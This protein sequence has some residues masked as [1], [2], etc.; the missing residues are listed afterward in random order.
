MLLDVN[1]NSWNLGDQG[2]CDPAP[3]L[4]LG[5]C[6][7]WREDAAWWLSQDP[8]AG[9]WQCCLITVAYSSWFLGSPVVIISPTS[10]SEEE[11]HLR[12]CISHDWRIVS[13]LTSAI[14]SKT[15]FRRQ[16]S[17]SHFGWFTD[18]QTKQ[19]LRGWRNT[20]LLFFWFCLP[21]VFDLSTY[22]LFSTFTL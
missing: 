12:A 3:G 9:P 5:P 1:K 21:T 15:A 19:N 4:A 20:W 16:G 14:P 18:K 17:Q 8:L 13:L 7:R 10:V 11:N 2:T 22:S 6:L